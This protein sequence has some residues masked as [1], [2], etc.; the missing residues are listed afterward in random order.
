[1]DDLKGRK[2]EKFSIDDVVGK[3][4]EIGPDLRARADF[5]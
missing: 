1:M 5:Y 4:R 2:I 3:I